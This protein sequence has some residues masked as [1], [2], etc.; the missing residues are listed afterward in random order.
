FSIEDEIGFQ[1]VK[2]DDKEIKDISS[3][4]FKVE[5]EKFSQPEHALKA[6]LDKATVAAKSHDGIEAIVANYSKDGKVESYSLYKATQA[7]VDKISQLSDEGKYNGKVARF[8]TPSSILFISYEKNTDIKSSYVHKPQEES[9]P[10]T[11]NIP[12]PSTNKQEPIIKNEVV[13]ENGKAEVV[14]T[15]PPVSDSDIVVTR[16]ETSKIPSYLL[17]PSLS[18]SS[19]YSLD[20][21]LGKLNTGN[22]GLGANGFDFSKPISLNNPPLVLAPEVLDSIQDPFGFCLPSSNL[23]EPFGYS[24]FTPFP[25]SLSLPLSSQLNSNSPSPITNNSSPVQTVKVERPSLN[26]KELTIDAESAKKHIEAI[27]KSVSKNFSDLSGA[28]VNDSKQL[29]AKSMEKYTDPKYDSLI[30][31]PTLKSAVVKLRNGESFSDDEIMGVAKSVKALPLD[32]LTPEQLL[33]VKDFESSFSDFESKMN[34]LKNS[35]IAL[36]GQLKEQTALLSEMSALVQGTDSKSPSKQVFASFLNNAMIASERKPPN[37]FEILTNNAILK[38][39]IDIINDKNPISLEQ[40]T[41]LKSKTLSTMND[42]LKTLPKDSR[43]YET[44]SQQI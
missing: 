25:L 19:K 18:N 26:I 41:Q 6:A 13:F 2:I 14:S 1:S 20:P 12:D 27:E 29:F 7:D 21:N 30:K 28:Y 3:N 39:S 17:N 9:K 5:Y 16:P 35:S 24:L 31:D 40:A 34:V 11:Q 32:K 36:D 44:L 37:A 33:A 8:V 22:I 10:Q 42:R 15:N 23:Y 43:E 38:A 4:E